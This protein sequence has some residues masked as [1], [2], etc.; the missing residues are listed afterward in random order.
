MK[1]FKTYIQGLILVW[2]LASCS[3]NSFV[4]IE[5]GGISERADTDMY[6]RVSVPR[7]YATNAAGDAKET[8]ITGI[9]VLVF[10]PGIGVDADKYYLKSASKGTPVENGKKFEVTMPVGSDLMVHVFAN[11]H[12]EFVRQG[13]Y[14]KVGLEMESLF[15]LLTTGVDNNAAGVADLPMHGFLSGVTVTKESVGQLLTVPLLRSVAAVRVATNATMDAD[16]NL[17]GRDIIDPATGNPIFS[18]RELYAYFPSDSGRIAPIMEAYALDGDLTKTRD[19]VKATLPPNPAVLPIER[20]YSILSNTDVKQL[21]NLYLYENTNY[22]DNGSDQPGTVQGNPKVATTRLV[23]GGIYKDEKQNDGT[24]KVT[25]YRVD[26]TRNDNQG[27]TKLV[28]VLRNHLY[29]LNIVNVSGSGYGDPDAAATGVPVN[30]DVK[31]IDWTNVDNNVDFDR[32]NWFSS[33]SK[34]IVMPR[35][36]NSVRT[37][38]METDVPFG[39]FWKLR[40]ESDNNGAVAPVTILDGATSATI[41]NGRYKIEITRTAESPNTKVSLSVTALKDYNPAPALPASRDE[42]LLIQVK[43]LSVRINITQVDKSP[44]DWGSGGEIDS[45]LE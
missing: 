4:S 18:L 37:I 36:Q 16:G 33:E 23:V 24:P 20:K 17:T 15:S 26:I 28:E 2:I 31:V 42:I 30:I 35:K 25:Y 38:R 43:N 9:D 19:V 8:L 13:I 40:F 29:T 3:D 44:D 41:Q 5:N 1:H 32:E 10:S 6:L 27:N 34:N 11:T 21:G 45:E 39:S 12:Q 22:S 7:T 14:G